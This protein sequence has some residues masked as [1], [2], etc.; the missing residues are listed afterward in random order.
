MRR[1]LYLS[2]TAFLLVIFLLILS[3]SNPTWVFGEGNLY[4]IGTT[5]E[6]ENVNST[7]KKTRRARDII[8]N[9]PQS[10]GIPPQ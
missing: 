10:K 2:I 8:Y 9:H 1:R 7:L 4:M 5:Y 3:L 6:M